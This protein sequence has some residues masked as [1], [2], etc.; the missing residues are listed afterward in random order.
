VSVRVW[1]H[2]KHYRVDCQH[3]PADRTTVLELW[4]GGHVAALPLTSGT[5]IVPVGGLV[6]Q[7]QPQ[8]HPAGFT[9]WWPDH[10][11]PSAD[12]SGSPEGSSVT[13]PAA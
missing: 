13:L 5:M 4:R 3:L 9:S 12:S 8:R 6:F 1:Q 2:Q 11:G 7:R 10:V